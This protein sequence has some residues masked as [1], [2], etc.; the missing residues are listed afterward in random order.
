MGLVGP[1]FV[2]G[3]SMGL[4]GGGAKAASGRPQFIP[5]TAASYSSGFSWGKGRVVP[6]TACCLCS[7]GVS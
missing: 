3:G 2:A 4:D 6:T 1:V 5:R 7:V